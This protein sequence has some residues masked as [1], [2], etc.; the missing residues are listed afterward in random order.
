MPNDIKVELAGGEDLEEIRTLFDNAVRPGYIALQSPF[1][2]WQYIDTPGNDWLPEGVIPALVS[3]SP[4]RILCVLLFTP[5]IFR[6]NG[7]DARGMMLSDW[8]SLPDTKGVRGLQ[9][10]TEAKRMAD[11]VIA[12]G[13]NNFVMPIYRRMRFSLHLWGRSVWVVDVEGLEKLMGQD[14]TEEERVLLTSRRDVKLTEVQI[15]DEL[16]DE[17]LMRCADIP[18]YDHAVKRDVRFLEWRYR[19]HPLTEYILKSVL[20]EKG[21]TIGILAANAERVRDRGERVLRVCEWISDPSGDAVMLQAVLKLAQTHCA[22]LI[23][24]FSPSTLMGE[25]LRGLGFLSIEELGGTTVPRLFQ[26]LELRDRLSINSGIF[27]ED[28]ETFGPK[29]LASWYF[30]KGDGNQDRPND[31]SYQILTKE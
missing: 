9:V 16:D 21:Q 20:N 6:V 5:T 14:Y 7:Q 28:E 17:F 19:A 26:P 23:D 12:P 25:R 4:E 8:Y 31:A 18:P 27:L 11:V 24:F 1:Y 29:D 10:M 22:I 3:R 15:S 13:M 30:T 2:E